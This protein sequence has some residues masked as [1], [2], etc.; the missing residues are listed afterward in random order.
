MSGRHIEI[1]YAEEE[2][3]CPSDVVPIEKAARLPAPGDNAAICFKRTEAGTKIKLHGGGICTLEHTILEGHRFANK[4]ITKG[5][6]VTSWG[7]PFGFALRDIEPGEYIVNGEL[8]RLQCD[9]GAG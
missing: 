6:A 9:Y 1:G 5:A 2:D 4:K 3:T 7:L 8:V